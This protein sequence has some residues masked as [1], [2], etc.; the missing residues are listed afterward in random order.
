M[1]FFVTQNYHLQGLNM[2]R[3]QL[4]S[5]TSIKYLLNPHY[6][7]DVVWAFLDGIVK[8]FNQCMAMNTLQG[9]SPIALV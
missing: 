3:S 1:L 5:M 9:A 4:V 2:V 7:V 6:Y 8:H